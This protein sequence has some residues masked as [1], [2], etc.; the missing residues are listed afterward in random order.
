MTYILL[1][2]DLIMEA[3]DGVGSLIRRYQTAWGEDPSQV[4]HV[5]GVVKGGSW[6]QAEIVEALWRVTR[7]GFNQLEGDL[8]VWRNMAWGY[9]D[10]QRV[11][12]ALID[13]V[14]Q[15][16]NPLRI[17][18]FLGD[19]LLSRYLLG[20]IFRRKGEVRLLRRL[21]A[22]PH[23]RVCSSVYSGATETG[24]GYLFGC[25][26]E[27]TTPD[28]MDD[29]VRAHQL[30]PAAGPTPEGHWRL[31]YTRKANLGHWHEEA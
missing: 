21:A 9:H 5:A 8:Y 10:Q 26:A 18:G 20:P 22:N 31:V 4:N 29:W 13:Q 15:L 25:D 19:N 17:I 27:Q 2:G 1:P 11:A 7:H 24:T 28:G 12:Q 3:S 30:D 16:Y 23:W 14:G 6:D